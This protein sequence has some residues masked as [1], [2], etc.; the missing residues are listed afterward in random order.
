MQG[1]DLVG[2]LAE[3]QRQYAD[4][5]RPVRSLEPTAT[6]TPGVILSGITTAKH[7][8]RSIKLGNE[9]RSGTGWL[10]FDLQALVAKGRAATKIQ[11]RTACTFH[12]KNSGSLCSSSR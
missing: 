12:V 4:A 7:R 1:I 6:A 2:K 11:P 3:M 10:R 5:H 8:F 9:D